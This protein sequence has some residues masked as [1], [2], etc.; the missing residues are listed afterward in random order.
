M[1]TFAMNHSPIFASATRLRARRVRYL[2]QIFRYVLDVNRQVERAPGFLGGKLLYESG[3]TFWTLTFWEDEAAMRA[4]QRS[5]V[6]QHAMPKL[7]DWCDEASVVHGNEPSTNLLGWQA[8]WRYM[9]A[10]GRMSKVHF[11][12]TAQRA[13]Q[14]AKP[15]PSPFEIRLKPMSISVKSVVSGSV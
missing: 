4:F 15:H 14:V 1:E 5:G 10:N 12:S 13:G 6:H 9:V 7:L 11:P 8:V 3:K 2:P